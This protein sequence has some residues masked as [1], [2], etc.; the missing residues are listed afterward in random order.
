MALQDVF[1]AFITIKEPETSGMWPD[2]FTD[3]SPDS[4]VPEVHTRARPVDTQLPFLL[5][6]QL[7]CQ[8][9]VILHKD[10]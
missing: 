4:H 7:S 8:Q 3:T 9:K 1:P 6:A 10:T 5:I 2:M